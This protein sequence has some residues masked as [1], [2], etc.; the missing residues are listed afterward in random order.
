[1]KLK[2]LLIFEDIVIQCHDNP[3]ADTLASAFG[4]YRYLRS[5][6][7]SP[8]IIYSGKHMI[9]KSNLTMMIHELDIPVEHVHTLTAPELLITVDCQYGEGNVT[10]FDARTIAIIDHHDDCGGKATLKEIHSFYSSCATVVYVMLKEEGFDVNAD[11]TLSTALYY[12]LY[13]DSNCFA[14]L[15]H[16]FDRDL[17]EDLT[18]NEALTEQLKYNNFSLKE[19]E[20]AGVALIRC[21]YE[22]NRRYALVRAGSCDP[23]I[24]GLISDLVIQVD[25][26]DCCV[27]YSETDD[28]I[29]FSVRSC[30]K[31]AT[32]NDIAIDLTENIGTGGGHKKKAGGFINSRWFYQQ[33]GNMG[34]E[35][36]LI[37]RLTAYFSSYDVIDTKKHI[38]DTESMQKYVKLP[39]PLGY[40]KTTDLETPGTEM[41][42]RT[43]EGDVRICANDNLFIL[44]GV[45]GEVYPI[46]KEKLLASYV[47][48]EKPFW[49]KMDYEPRVKNLKYGKAIELMA[50]TKQCIPTGRSE[51]YAKQLSKTTKVLSK[52]NYDNYML[53]K[54][55]DYLACRADD[56]QDI[57][58]I[59]ES[60]FN[61]TYT[62]APE[63][64]ES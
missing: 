3:D 27:V 25:H 47:I 63:G 9:S 30:L 43:L 45:N 64:T 33:N 17:A 32:A 34:I 13:M 16:P 8:R 15:K 26:V 14:E 24:L 35:N 5:F 50:H 4:V 20:I 31:L 48:T 60:I 11:T 7:K 61:K 55:N 42:I 62:P 52:W 37:N 40:V 10:K 29:R 6:G 39:L 23:N 36:Y 12:G 53:G 18:V 19:L 59:K 46:M 1:M 21:I 57:Y 51:I 49:A 54:K 2:D 56:M 22:E 41:I 38:P 44:V 28:N 58:I